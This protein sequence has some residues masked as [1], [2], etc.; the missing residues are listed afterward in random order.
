MVRTYLV[1]VKATDF[2]HKVQRFVACKPDSTT[3]SQVLTQSVPRRFQ[4]LSSPFFRICVW[5][6]RVLNESRFGD[7]MACHRNRNEAKNARKDDRAQ[8]KQEYFHS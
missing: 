4:S 2:L 5:E 8:L 3:F 6:H 1:V 7:D